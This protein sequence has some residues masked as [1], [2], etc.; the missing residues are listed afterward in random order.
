MHGDGAGMRPT[1]LSRKDPWFTDA[2]QGKWNLFVCSV[3]D[4]LT[5]PL[6]RQGLQHQLLVSG[7]R[8]NLFP[9]TRE[10]MLAPVGRLRLLVPS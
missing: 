1:H 3:K 4:L 10:T 7:E 5:Q 6:T 2:A 9:E 8:L